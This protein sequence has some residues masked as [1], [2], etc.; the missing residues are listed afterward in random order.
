MNMKHFPERIRTAGNRLR[1]RRGNGGG[2]YLSPERVVLLVLFYSS[3]QLIS[4]D[5]LWRRAKQERISI[6][7]QTTQRFLDDMVTAGLAFE[8]EGQYGD[9]EQLAAKRAAVDTLEKRFMVSQ[10]KGFPVSCIAD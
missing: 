5:A 6:S 2:K 9:A 3:P 8:N 4:A 1:R 7:R 10:K